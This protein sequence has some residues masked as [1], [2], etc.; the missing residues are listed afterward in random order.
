MY[1]LQKLVPQIVLFG[2][3]AEIHVKNE[4]LVIFGWE[5]QISFGFPIHNP[6]NAGC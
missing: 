3:L 4:L 6:E 5:L 2:D 1:K